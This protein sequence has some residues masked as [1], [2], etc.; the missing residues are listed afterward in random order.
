MSADTRVPHHELNVG[1]I[2]PALPNISA[3]VAARPQNV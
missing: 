2:A 1:H 3:D